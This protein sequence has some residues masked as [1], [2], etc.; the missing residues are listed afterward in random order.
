MGWVMLAESLS[1]LAVTSTPSAPGENETARVASEVARM[2]K[3]PMP[4]ASMLMLLLDSV[5]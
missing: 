2:P 5:L 4:P 1:N 3:L